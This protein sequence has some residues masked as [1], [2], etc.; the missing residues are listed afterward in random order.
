MK[1]LFKGFTIASTGDFGKQR[2]AEAIKRW[3][4]NN[5]GRYITKVDGE[6][7][8]LVCSTEYWKSQSAMG[9]SD[10]R[11]ESITRAYSVSKWPMF[12]FA[13]CICLRTHGGPRLRVCLIDFLTNIR[14]S[15][16][17]ALPEDQDR[18]L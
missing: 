12:G 15:S 9:E 3:V 6:V 16:G 17:Q 18:H 10:Q 1:N 2:T 14:S 5:G 11:S 4:E 7:T 8:H 13:F